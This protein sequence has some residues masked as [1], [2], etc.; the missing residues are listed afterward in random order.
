M[1]RDYTTARFAAKRPSFFSKYFYLLL[2]IRS[3]SGN[4]GT[5]STLVGLCDIRY[6]SCTLIA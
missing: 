1:S 2:A 4:E 6:L 3:G 5:G